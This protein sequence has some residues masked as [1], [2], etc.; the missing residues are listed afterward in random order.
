MSQVVHATSGARKGQGTYFGGACRRDIDSSQF[1]SGA[2]HLPR[3]HGWLRLSQRGFAFCL[4]G[5]R[6]AE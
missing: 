4:H 1:D 2:L 6:F 3:S 5:F